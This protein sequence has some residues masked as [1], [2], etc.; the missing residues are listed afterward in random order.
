[1]SWKNDKAILRVYNAFKRS[2]DKIYKEDIEALKQLNDELKNNEIKY[3]NDNLLFAKLLCYTFNQ[4]L[5]FHGNIK[6]AIKS[7]SD[8]L[9]EPLGFHLQ[10]LH[11]NINS[12]KIEE[13]L[14]SKGF[15]LDHFN[16]KE[17]GNDNL[18]QEN[19]KSGDEKYLLIADKHVCK[20]LKGKYFSY[21]FFGIVKYV[22]VLSS[23]TRKLEGRDV[24][25]LRCIVL[26]NS[27]NTKSASNQYI[28]LPEIGL[29]N[30]A[31]CV[32]EKLAFELLKK[33]ILKE[34]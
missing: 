29:L 6:I 14:L 9:K 10:N 13:F 12:K 23:E 17:N 3:V 30:T 22:H 28:E 32:V 1:M 26:R 7:A 33:K 5:H 16:H 18:L 27:N 31:Y 2:K 25:V 15:E 21:N 4:N 19:E 34:I 24:H 11:K 20:L 8:I